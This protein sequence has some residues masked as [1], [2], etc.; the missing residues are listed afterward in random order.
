[1]KKRQGGQQAQGASKK[2][3][4][5]SQAKLEKAERKQKAKKGLDK[6]ELDRWTI[7]IELEWFI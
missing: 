4:A 1:M 3:D 6:N 7:R 5:L 2:G